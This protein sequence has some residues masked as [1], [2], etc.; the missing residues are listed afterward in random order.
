MSFSAV[1][2]S[3]QKSVKGG[4]QI[5]LRRWLEMKSIDMSSL[6][7]STG[8]LGWAPACECWCNRRIAKK[9]EMVV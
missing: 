3:R 4:Q 5:T 9:R 2:G 8:R 7:S 6:M 1:Q